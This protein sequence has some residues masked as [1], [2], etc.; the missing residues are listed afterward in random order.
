[1]T[2][3]RSTL[4]IPI[5]HKAYDLCKILQNYHEHT[6][7]SMRYTIWQ[8]CE[9]TALEMLE[10]IITTGHQ[11]DE[12]KKQTLYRI[13]TQLDLLKVLIRLAKDI[14]KIENKVY[15]DLQNLLQEIGKMIGGWIRFASH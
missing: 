14:G 11:R 3:P 4:D 8:K 9:T 7:K 1:M 12:Q 5:F 6:P 2:H 13:S 15:I 10:S